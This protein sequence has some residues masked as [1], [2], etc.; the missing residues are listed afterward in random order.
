MGNYYV[1]MQNEGV[2]DR[3]QEIDGEKV[4]IEGFEE[5][6]LF[7]HQPPESSMTDLWVISEG[8]TGL[9]ITGWCVSRE[10]ARQEAKGKLEGAGLSAA[11]AR[12]DKRLA[13]SQ[14]P[15]YIPEKTK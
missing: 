13:I 6:D 12:V 15:R 8:E 5:L 9:A 1:C 2:A 4:I 10:E 3:Y 7:I 14:S 11:R